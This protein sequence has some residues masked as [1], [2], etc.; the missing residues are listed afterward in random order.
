[1]SNVGMSEM[2]AAR[3]RELESLKKV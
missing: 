1:M 2:K 3:N